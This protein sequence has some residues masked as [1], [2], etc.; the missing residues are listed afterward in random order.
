M[1][2][3]C[4]CSCSILWERIE[5]LEWREW[6]ASCTN[7]AHKHGSVDSLEVLASLNVLFTSDLHESILECSVIDFIFSSDKDFT[8]CG[9]ILELVERIMLRKFLEEADEIVKMKNTW[10]LL[11][12]LFKALLN[13]K[14]ICTKGLE[15]L[16]HNFVWPDVWS[17]PSAVC[18]KETFDIE[19]V[20]YRW[21]IEVQL[22]KDSILLWWNPGFEAKII[23][24]LDPFNLCEC[25]LSVWIWQEPFVGA[26]STITQAFDNIGNFTV[27]IV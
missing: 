6:V 16:F 18:F 25:I 13:E 4:I 14:F 23:K 21:F 9:H 5:A 20:N 24:R 19:K 11:R 12:T 8:K 22:V 7:T 10:V 27:M 26:S 17:F 15:N 2:C 1:N 3:L